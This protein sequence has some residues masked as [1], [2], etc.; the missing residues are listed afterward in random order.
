[1]EA[2][3]NRRQEPDGTGEAGHP[4]SASLDGLCLTG[5]VDYR[6]EPTRN[7]SVPSLTVVIVEFVQAAQIVA[8]NVVTDVTS[9]MG[10]RFLVEA[11]VDA[12]VNAGVA[13]VVGDLVPGGVVEDDARHRGIGQSDGK[14]I[15]AE[16][17]LE[18]R[19]GGSGHGPVARCVAGVPWGGDQ[20]DPG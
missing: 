14:A 1:M 3:V 19:A 10:P 2:A 11:E 4:R 20:R 5:R 9:L 18:H 12:A 6:C 7:V 16:G 13:D 8:E 17:P 15:L